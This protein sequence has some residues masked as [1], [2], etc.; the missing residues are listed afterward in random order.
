MKNRHFAPFAILWIVAMALAMNLSVQ[1]QPA[2]APAKGVVYLDA[3]KN[4]QRDD[5]EKGLPGVGVSNGV[6]VVQT[7]ES[8]AWALPYDDET[9]FFVIKPA[10]FMTPTDVN[11][12][13]R[14]YYVHQPKG[15][16][17]HVKDHRGVAPTGPLPASID[18]PLH[19]APGESKEFPALIMGDP[20]PRNRT[21]IEYLRD[22]IVAQLLDNPASFAVCLGDIMFDDLSHY[23][24]YM[25]VMR[26][27]GVPVYNVPGNHDMNY[28]STDD[29][30]SMETWKA[31]FGPPYYSFNYGDVHYIVIDNVEYQGRNERGH[32]RYIGKIGEKQIN[33]IREDLKF[34]PQ[35]KLIVMMHHIP[36]RTLSGDGDSVNT[37]DRRALFEILA[38]R[39]HVLDLAAHTHTT[40]HL[41]LGD[42]EG[43]KG[44]NPLHC[45]QTTTPCGAWWSGPKDERG[46]PVTLQRDGTPNGWHLFQF[47]GNAYT[48]RYYG[49]NLPESAQLRVSSPRGTL[50]QD[51]LTTAELVINVFNGGSRSIV[52]ARIGGAPIDVTQTRRTDPYFVE[53]HANHI[54][55]FPDWIKPSNSTHLWVGA[56][57]KG[58]KPGTHAV[59]VRTVDQ[60][61]Q[62]FWGGG[63]FD[64]APKSA[65]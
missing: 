19:A 48:E 45:M 52:E 8:G 46:I 40:E 3:N 51:A 39:P 29:V 13:P 32:P 23:G 6:T 47:K 35:D 18:F 1:A 54:G 26:G 36:M 15:S 55:D 16:P 41:Y 25:D 22:D 10:G 50:S 60:Y 53:Y 64:I 17:P 37:T 31:T 43:W 58:L 12:I 28:D 14:F 61:G 30:Y 21:E 5:G 49:A 7:D 20:Q 24:Y 33:W 2:A 38:G 56:L 9:V 42:E 4:G 65:E 59:H 57:P 34:V 62:E 44:E 11:N 27:L 63:L